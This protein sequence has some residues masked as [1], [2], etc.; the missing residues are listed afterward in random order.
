MVKA[1][2]ESGESQNRIVLLLGLDNAGKTT[3]LYRLKDDEF[4]DTV[5]TIGLN[6][7]EITHQGSKITLWDVSGKSR[8]LWKHY[9]DRVDGILF[10]VDST[11]I[12]KIEDVKEELANLMLEEILKDVPIVVLCNKQDVNTDTSV[13]KQ[14]FEKL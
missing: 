14:L 10:V 9:Y 3:L 2:G 11:D 8:K 7:E 5:P 6:I 4:V 12:G 1:N 13:E